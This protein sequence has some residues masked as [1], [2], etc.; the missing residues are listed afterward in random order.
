ML[1]LF[2][3]PMR[4]PKWA[5]GGSQNFDAKP[6]DPNTNESL[7]M[8]LIK[9]QNPML[10][11]SPHS[12]CLVSTMI[13]WRLWP[14]EVMGVELAELK[15]FFVARA[16]CLSAGL[17]YLR[18]SRLPRHDRGPVP[19]GNR[20]AASCL[21]TVLR[22]ALYHYATRSP[23][24][25]KHGIRK[26]GTLKASKTASI[27]QSPQ[28]EAAILQN[29]IG[30]FLTPSL[31]QICWRLFQV[32][33]DLISNSCGWNFGL[34]RSIFARLLFLHF[35]VHAKVQKTCIEDCLLVCCD[36]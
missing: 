21:C 30:L 27:L 25:H 4:A 20:C 11:I 17:R 36:F 19:G 5:Y 9:F 26:N 2:V 8:T 23:S 6:L 12:S 29:C 18:L 14:Q 24:C 31:W 33:A 28:C 7:Q 22:R 16:R 13:T 15:L 1:G 10:Q 32:E 35:E 34:G 3:C